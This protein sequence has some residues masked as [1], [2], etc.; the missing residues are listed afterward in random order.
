MLT[1]SSPRP[2]DPQNTDYEYEGSYDD[3]GEDYGEY[4]TGKLPICFVRSQ[5]GVM[6]ANKVNLVISQSLEESK[7]DDNFLSIVIF[8]RLN[9]KFISHNRKQTTL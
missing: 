5:R 3:Y 1:Y 7:A 8:K 2:Q 4:G 6:G 9:A